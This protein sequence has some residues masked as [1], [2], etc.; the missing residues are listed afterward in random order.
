VE[1]R[2]QS[3]PF[4][5]NLQRYT[6]GVLHIMDM[7]RNLR[8]PMHKEKDLMKKFL[9]REL[10]RVGDVAERVVTRQEDLKAR[11]EAEKDAAGAAAPAEGGAAEKKVELTGDEKAEAEYKSL[12]RQ[13]MVTMGLAEEA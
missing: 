1:N 3:L 2:F 7:P 4:K 12:E 6:S 13:F 8:R 5:C 10:D 11:E 9:T